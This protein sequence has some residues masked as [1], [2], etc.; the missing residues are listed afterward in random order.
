MDNTTT[1]YNWIQD[2]GINEMLHTGAQELAGAYS[3]LLYNNPDNSQSQNW[4][5]KSLDWANYNR[6]IKDLAFD[7]KDKAEAEIEKIALELKSVLNLERTLIGNKID[8]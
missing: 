8:A 6:S 2:F 4:Q 1:A 3:R 7:T 5:A